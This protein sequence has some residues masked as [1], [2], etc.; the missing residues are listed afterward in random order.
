MNKIDRLILK[1][2]EAARGGQELTVAII[3][4]SGNSWTAQAHLS[5]GVPGHIP[6]IKQAAYTTLEAAVAYIRAI[7]DEYPNSQDVPVIIDDMG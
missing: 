7:A 4:R 6:S 3:E 2:K 5:D 1:A